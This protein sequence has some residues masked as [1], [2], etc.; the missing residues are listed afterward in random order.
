MT[1]L[2]D[3]YLARCSLCLSGS[4]QRYALVGAVAALG[5]FV[6]VRVVVI[7]TFVSS[8]RSQSKGS[9]FDMHCDT[10]MIEYFF[11]SCFIVKSNKRFIEE[12]FVLVSIYLQK[13]TNPYFHLFQVFEI[14]FHR[15]ICNL[16]AKYMQFHNRNSIGRYI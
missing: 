4:R 8:S 10:H 16:Y 7:D 11:A 5:I 14:F 12:D 13:K 9:Y 1:S 3:A 15:F 6:L 2:S